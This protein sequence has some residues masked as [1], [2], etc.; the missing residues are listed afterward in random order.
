MIDIS[1]ALS[2]ALVSCIGS[3]IGLFFCDYRSLALAGYTS[4]PKG[5]YMTWM[6]AT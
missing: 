4:T 3:C 6:V 5:G 1:L 2:L